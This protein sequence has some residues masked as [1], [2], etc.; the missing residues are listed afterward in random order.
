MKRHVMS[1][2]TITLK[3]LRLLTM[4]LVVLVF[5][6]WELF[7]HS[8]LHPPQRHILVETLPFT[9]L[10]IVLI[11]LLYGAVIK[12][13]RRLE[14]SNKH[15]ASLQNHQASILDGS[16]NAIIVVDNQGMI[17]SFN[18]QAESVCGYA[19]GD[20]IGT[21][22]LRLFKER[23]RIRRALDT[24]R[25]EDNVEIV[26]D[27]SIIA[28][29]GAE[30]PVSL[31]LRRIK[32]GD[33]NADGIVLVV[34]DLQERK[35]LEHRL[36]V[37]EKMAAVSQLAAGM[38]HEIR[39][40]LASIDVNMRNLEDQITCSD[41]QCDECQKYFSRISSESARLKSLA[42]SFLSSV[43][44]RRIEASPSLCRL[45]QILNASLERCRSALEDK[46]VHVTL[47]LSSCPT[48]VECDRP[49]LTQSFCNIVQNGV[50]AMTSPGEL[51]IAIRQDGDWSQVMFR[52]TGC[53]IPRENL[54]RIFDFKY[55][56]KRG[57]FGVGL[58]F[59]SL[60]VEQHGG[61][62]EVQSSV[63]RGTCVVVWLPA[64][65]VDLNEHRAEADR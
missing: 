62:I 3:R 29:R 19:P 30:V 8:F 45:D 49:Q 56:T 44:P 25:S 16:P 40:P 6:A 47:D 13:C 52:D 17:R 34:E 33:D 61:R 22:G 2:E 50:E 41:R 53:G 31:L 65:K 46:T 28:K 38:A 20:A 55:S 60:V 24:A 42:E 4:S 35:R 5:W 26:E 64:N 9:T 1:P 27:T 59:A 18:R 63:G 39:N 11:Y 32:D 12:S 15:L 43:V 58:S 48:Y 14:E 7:E 51:S 57:G 21:D 10:L 54:E 37:S 23:N 36:I